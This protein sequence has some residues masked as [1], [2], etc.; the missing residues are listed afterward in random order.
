MLARQ[1]VLSKPIEIVFK[2]NPDLPEVEHDSSQV[3]Q[4]LLNLLLNA[5]QALDTQ[6]RIT[7]AMEAR[8]LSAAIVVADN[9]RG[10]APEHLPNIFRPFYTTKSNG[11]GLGLSLAR[12]IIEQHQGT[13]DVVSKVGQGTEFTVLL[14]IRRSTPEEEVA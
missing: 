14:P 5:I 12:R 11:T 8:K 13:L 9:G 10:I 7:V 6:G 1:Q 2:K 4:V 3:H